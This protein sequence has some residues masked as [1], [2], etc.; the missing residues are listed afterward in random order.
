MFTLTVTMR[1]GQSMALHYEKEQAA[2]SA[3]DR[4]CA[5]SGLFA[6]ESD[7]YGRR[8]AVLLADVQA[9]IVEDMGKAM[10]SLVQTQLLQ[11]RAQAELER[12][13]MKDGQIAT[14]RTMVG[15]M[16]PNGGL[17]PARN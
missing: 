1:G 9:V 15:L 16:N 11:R 10:D 7:A 13:T 4:V 2:R 3:Q 8:L 14:T 6:Q 5:A 17:I 12:L